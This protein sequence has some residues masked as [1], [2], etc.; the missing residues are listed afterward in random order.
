MLN[1]IVI[2]YL[3]ADGFLALCGGLILTSALISKFRLQQSQEQGQTIDNVAQFLLLERSPLDIA[4][5]NAS[6]IF[7]T[8]VISIPAILLR[9]NRIWL[10]LHGWTVVLSALFTLCLGLYLWFQTLTTRTLAGKWWAE[11]GAQVQSLLQS[12]WNCCGYLDST[13]PPFQI[14]S[15]CPTFLAAALKDGCVGP[16]SSFVNKYLDIAFTSLF[17]IVGVHVI[18]LL[19]IAMVL[20]DSKERARYN[21]IDLK[22]GFGSI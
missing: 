9:Q 8:F 7:L 19:C 22:N 21:S 14:D 20:E 17:G 5:T 12:K 15:T 2:T 16:F 3:I 11:Q 10:K 13:S 6:A 4:V 18:V 1:K